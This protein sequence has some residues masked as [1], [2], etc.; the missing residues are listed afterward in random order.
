VPGEAA[1]AAGLF[2]RSFRFPAGG[3]LSVSARS[4]E[5]FGKNFASARTVMFRFALAVRLDTKANCGGRE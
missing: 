2:M 4:T 5:E 3:S 1:V